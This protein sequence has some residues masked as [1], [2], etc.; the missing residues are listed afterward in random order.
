MNSDR[1]VALVTG[2]ARR[3]GRAIALELADAGCDV[4]IHFLNSGDDA[5]TLAEEIQRRGRR[6]IL[7]RGDLGDP[8]TWPAIVAQTVAELGRMDVL[9]NNASRFDASG[10]DTL[11]E[12]DS[13]RWDDMLRVNVT[14]C[15]GLMHHAAPHL[16]TGRRGRIVNLCD[17][18]ADRPW[19]RHVAYC[20]SKAALAA[21]TRSAARALAPHI[22]VNAVSPGIAEFPEEFTAEL[23]DKLLAR[24][25]LRRAGTPLEVARIVRFLV[26]D[27]DYITGQIIAVDGGRGLA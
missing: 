9:I 23:R 13:A 3:V 27:G 24:V 18:A 21:L 25:P 4:A 26:E 6:A 11:D 7:T 8:P 5:R 14:A 15:A 20:A 19:R 2:A 17:I 16:R 1:T 10:E 12:F 22:L